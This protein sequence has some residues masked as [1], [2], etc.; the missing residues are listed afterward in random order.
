MSK[1]SVL[2]FLG[3]V[4]PVLIFIFLKI[5]GKNQFDVPLVYQDGVKEVP[6][7]CSG[8][9]A[10]PYRIDERVMNAIAP[11]RGR[12]LV[13]INFGEPYPKLKTVVAKFPDEVKL[14]AAGQIHLGEIDFTMLKRCVLLMRDPAD[15]VL[16]DHE[17]NIR[18]YYD[19]NDRD[20]LDRLEAELIIILKKY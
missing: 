13:L 18:G 3:L 2:L 1:K 4:L 17:R 16:I 15:L 8:A 11:E 12:S 5:F 20:D 9:F 14:L 19:G 6:E 7:G 10:A